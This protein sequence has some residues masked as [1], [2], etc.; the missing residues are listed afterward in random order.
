MNFAVNK[1]SFEQLHSQRGAMA[2][3]MNILFLNPQKVLF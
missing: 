3:C 1:M 2:G